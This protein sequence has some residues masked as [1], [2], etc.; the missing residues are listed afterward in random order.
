MHLLEDNIGENLHDLG[1]DEN[2]SCNRKKLKKWH[3]IKIK[4]ICA[5][6]DIIKKIGG[7]EDGEI[8]GSRA[9]FSLCPAGTPSRSSE[10]QSE[11]PT[12]SQFI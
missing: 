12:L 5:S 11:Q 3:F 6:K 7:G 1:L 9:Q 4:N 2:M 8:G 10:E